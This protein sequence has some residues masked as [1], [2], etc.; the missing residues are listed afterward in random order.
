MKV[1][2]PQISVVLIKS[3]P[4]DELVPGIKVSQKRYN[5]GDAVDLM[6]FLGDGSMVSTQK[7][8]RQPMGAFSI[9]FAD[10]RDGRLLDSLSALVEPGDL[11]EIRM[12][13]SKARSGV[14]PLVMRGYVSSVSRQEQMGGDGRPQRWVTIAGNDLQKLLSTYRISYKLFSA[15]G[16]YALDSFKFFTAFAGNDAIKTTTAN[17]F[18]KMTVE[19]IINPHLSRMRTLTRVFSED[20][21]VDTAATSA[22]VSWEMEST[23]DGTIN[24]T[25]L[26]S[27]ID[28]SL[29]DLLR[30]LLDVPT[31]NELFVEDRDGAPPVLRCRPVPFKDINGQFIQAGASAESMD[32]VSEDIV[33]MST[34]RDDNGVANYFWVDSSRMARLGLDQRAIALDGGY[35]SFTRLNAHNSSE[36]IH[37]LRELSVDT[38]MAGVDSKQSDSA[39]IDNLNKEQ[40]DSLDWVAQRRNT[41]VSVNENNILYETCNL[42]VKGDPNIK[43]GM[44]IRL[45]R[46]ANQTFVG[47]GYCHSVQHSFQ[48]M[49]GYVTQVSMDRYTGFIEHSRAQDPLYIAEIESQGVS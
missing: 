41:L 19:K 43:P 47:E 7:S 14:L 13:H 42:T 16:D 10:Q 22:V 4:R 2:A 32:I 40:R 26:N 17:E 28:I 23:V 49:V 12:A 18:V 20:D 25:V 5:R 8:I 30:M 39:K 6:P 44:F 1:L 34:H 31:F 35:E 9:K 38:A 29:Y 24:G 11:V 46:G 21:I 15:T 3:L 33:S 45:Y 27:A 36:A 48:P 37:G